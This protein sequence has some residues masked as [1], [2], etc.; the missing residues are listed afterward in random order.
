ME[1]KKAIE[2]INKDKGCDCYNLGT[3]KGYSV[4]DLVNTFMKVNDINVLL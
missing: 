1:N 2:K 3:G 4:L